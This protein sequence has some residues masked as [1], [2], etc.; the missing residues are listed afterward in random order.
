MVVVEDWRLCSGS[1]LETMQEG[2][3]S[4]GMEGFEGLGKEVVLNIDAVEASDLM[5]WVV[6]ETLFWS[7]Y[8]WE[9]AIDR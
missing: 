6:W 9:E 1:S 5:V 7:R 8:K 3:R 2:R 4:N